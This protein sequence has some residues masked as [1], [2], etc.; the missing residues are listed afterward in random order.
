MISLIIEKLS[1]IQNTA[2]DEPRQYGVIHVIEVVLFTVFKSKLRKKSST[3]EGR[4]KRRRK[5][6]RQPVIVVDLLQ[7]INKTIHLHAISI[8]LLFIKVFDVF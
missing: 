2:A 4:G 3:I 5:L 6:T 8:G 1:A 7:T